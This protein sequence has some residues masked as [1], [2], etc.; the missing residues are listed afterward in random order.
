[1]RSLI[2]FGI[3]ELQSS[4]AGDC[5][6]CN[7]LRRGLKE[8]VMYALLSSTWTHLHSAVTN[9]TQLRNAEIN[10]TYA[11]RDFREHQ[12]IWHTPALASSSWAA[13]ARNAS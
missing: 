10:L 9:Q 7:Q 6:T 3:E 11:L 13:A 2:Q 12:K 1:V 8:A 5:P 4:H